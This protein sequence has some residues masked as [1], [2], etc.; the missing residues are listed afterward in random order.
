[1]PHIFSPHKILLA[2]LSISFLCNAR[3]PEHPRPHVFMH[4]IPTGPVRTEHDLNIQIGARSIPIGVITS[5]IAYT[6]NS[7]ALHALGLGVLSGLI[8]GVITHHLYK[9]TLPEPMMN[10][11][12]TVLA[13][14]FAQDPTPA[15]KELLHPPA[16]AAQDKIVQQVV[17]SNQHFHHPYSVTEEELQRASRTLHELQRATQQT[18]KKNMLEREPSEPVA[19]SAKETLQRLEE[20]QQLIDHTLAKL[21]TTEAYDQEQHAQQRAAQHAAELAQQRAQAHKT[22]AE[23]EEKEAHAY[24][25][26]R[27]ADAEY[28]RAQAKRVQA[29]AEL[30]KK[31]AEATNYCAQAYAEVRQAR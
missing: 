29:Q 16:Q 15:V 10:T 8:T 14:R 9:D 19:Q 18:L 6:C 31:T 27:E 11:I 5:I 17:A 4:D 12:Q 7:S 21:H 22:E 2:A 23:A 3:S 28:E 25:R 26:R 24:A 13:E 20:L 1:M 30:R